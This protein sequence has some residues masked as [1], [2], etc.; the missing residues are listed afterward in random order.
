MI[1]RRKGM[2][3]VYLNEAIALGEAPDEVRNIFR[4]R[5]RWCKGQMQVRRLGV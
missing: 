5:S 1:M 2:K 4:Q 3:A